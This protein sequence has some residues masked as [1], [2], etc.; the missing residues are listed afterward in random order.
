M[1]RLAAGAFASRA[2]LRAGYLNFFDD[3]E[4]GFFK[5]DSQVRLEIATW[6]CAS[7]PSTLPPAEEGVEDVTKSSEYVGTFEAACTATTVSGPSVTEAVVA[8]STFRVS[9]NLVGLVYLF[10]FFSGIRVFVPIWMEL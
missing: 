10:E 5:G 3:T 9:E 7:S 1:P 8:L 2:S 6:T 4:D